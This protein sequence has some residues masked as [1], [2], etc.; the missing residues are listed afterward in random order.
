MLREAADTLLTLATLLGFAGFSEVDILKVDI[1]G[2]ELELFSDGIRDCLPRIRMIVVETHDRFRSGSEAAVHR[3]LA[4]LFEEK[5]SSGE[6][7][8][9]TRKK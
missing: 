9:F 6:N 3:A 5:S 8:I 2:A 4:P 7:T 1:E